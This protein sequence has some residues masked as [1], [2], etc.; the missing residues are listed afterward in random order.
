MRKHL[1]PAAAFAA[2][3]FAAPAVASAADALP[4]TGPPPACGTA[5]GRQL[6]VVGLTADS[7]LVC[8]GENNPGK[9]RTIGAIS[10]LVQDSAIV[11]IDV[12]PATGELYGLG[13]AGGVYTLGTSDAV[14]TLRS[15]LNVPLTA[16]A[17]GV[18][19]NPTVDRLRIVGDDGQNLR[20]DVT[21]GAATVDSDLTITPPT[22]TAGVVGAAYTNNDADPN[23]ATTL[24]DVDSAL[25]QIA[26]QAPPNNGTLN[27]TG[28]LGVDTGPAVGVDIYSSLKNGTTVRNEMFASL[29]A[30]GSTTFYAVNPL[31]GKANPRGR[32]EA[33]NQV[34]GI[35]LPANQD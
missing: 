12:R 24:F 16:A 34:I 17:F 4:R 14:A 31:T 18:D 8:F 23:T 25:D 1:I 20:V 28:K 32:F 6:Q 5:P 15:R 7:R 27:A 35:A 10:G 3:L 33:A 11:G 26:I 2:A 19:F 30:G 13:N 21:T 9:A 29:S 22:P